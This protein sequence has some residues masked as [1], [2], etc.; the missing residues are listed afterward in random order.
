MIGKTNILLVSLVA[1][2]S[3]GVARAEST[4]KEY[5][6]SQDN[7]LYDRM[8]TQDS[9]IATIR[10]WV[11]PK[12]NG[13]RAELTTEADDAYRAINEINAALAG[14]ANV[15]DVPAAQVNSDWNAESGVAQILNK[16]DLSQYATTSA[17][18]TALADKQDTISDI[19]TIRS[20]A[21]AGAT[22]VQPAALEGY[23]TTAEL[24]D[25]ATTSAMNTALADKQDTISDIET[26]RSG[27]A[28]GATAVQPAALEGYA[29]TAEL[30]DYATTSA[31]NT[32]LADKQDTISDIETIRSGATAGATAVQP[33]ALED[34]ATTSAM[35]TALADK[36]DTIDS[37]H[38]LSYQLVD[39][40]ATVAHTGDYAN[41]VNKPTI[42]SVAG[43]ATETYVDN[44]VASVVAGDMT[45]ALTAYVN[46]TE[47]VDT[48]LSDTSTNPV[49]NK[50]LTVELGGKISKGTV[51]SPGQ[52]VLGFVDG[53]QTY[54][55][56]VD[57][58]GD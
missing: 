50:V 2:M 22:A 9:R 42:P 41:L 23:A 38:P 43:L 28:A 35:N 37:E 17:M 26:I 49:Q 30:A 27:A 44:K 40:L 29:T 57:A 54:I 12:V 15:A 20:G 36:Q 51:P 7:Q 33:A 14:K 18:N 21:A 1:M 13:V 4:T 24:A 25:Y 46:K 16:P 6:D 47:D 32:A 19:E 45:E 52:Y 55:K 56:I 34:Y 58:D 31:M 10:D 11:N 39:G 5:V 8:R 3:V 53:V 48:E